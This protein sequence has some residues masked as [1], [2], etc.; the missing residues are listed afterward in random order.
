MSKKQL[1]RVCRKHILPADID[2]VVREP[3]VP[4]IPDDWN[5]ILVLAES[6]NLSKTNDTYVDSLKSLTKTKRFFRLTDPDIRLSD[7]NNVGVQPW[8]DGSLKLAVQSAFNVRAM[9]CAV[10]NSVVW[11]QV[12][13]GKNAN[14]SDELVEF[15]TEFWDELLLLII[16]EHIVTSGKKAHRV[17][18]NAKHRPWRHTKLRLPSRN[19]MSRISGMFPEKELLSRYPEVKKVIEEHPEFVNG[20]YR[21]NKIFFACHAV[22]VVKASEN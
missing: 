5:G 1:I 4:F 13:K 18:E 6:Q 20:R 8:D 3:Y 2:A 10:S 7:P 12:K 15:S 11:S 19:A 21:Q 17:I 9:S 14:P 22:S 16:P